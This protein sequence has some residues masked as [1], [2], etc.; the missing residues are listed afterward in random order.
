MQIQVTFLVPETMIRLMVAV[1]M[2]SYL[3]EIISVI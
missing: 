1:Q 3:T 2:F